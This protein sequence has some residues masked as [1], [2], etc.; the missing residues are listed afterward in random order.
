MENLSR[1]WTDILESRLGALF[2]GVPM[3]RNSALYALVW[4]GYVLLASIDSAFR[5]ELPHE[6]WL[7]TAG[8]PLFIGN[9]LPFKSFVAGA[10][11]EDTLIL[12]YTLVPLLLWVISFGIIHGLFFFFAAL[13]SEAERRVIIF[14]TAR[15]AVASPV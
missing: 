4:S 15:E 8:L 9:L 2:F 12:L 6:L 1:L 10:D 5:G 13:N 11:P 14:E 7:A 3:M